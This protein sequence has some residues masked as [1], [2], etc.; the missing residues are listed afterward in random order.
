MENNLLWIA[1]AVLAAVW[2]ARLWISIRRDRRPEVYSLSDEEIRRLERGG[3]IRIDAPT[4]LEEVAEE[5][6]RFWEESWDE[7]NEPF[8]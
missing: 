2:G 4:D 8:G 6:A 5:E 3:S 1:L 7:P